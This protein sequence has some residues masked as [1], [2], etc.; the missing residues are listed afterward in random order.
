M[1]LSFSYIPLWP[2]ARVS[3]APKAA[4]SYKRKSISILKFPFTTF[5]NNFFIEIYNVLMQTVKN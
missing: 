2:N 1:E 5:T 4:S 3:P